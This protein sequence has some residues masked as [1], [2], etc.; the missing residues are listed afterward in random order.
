MH[1]RSCVFDANEVLGF[2]GP[3]THPQLR[4]SCDV[5]QANY[6]SL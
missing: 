1:V 6:K 2:S 4:S 5:F 3:S